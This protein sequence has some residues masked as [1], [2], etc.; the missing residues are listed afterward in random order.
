MC[1]FLILYP[2][3][4][5]VIGS[6]RT[7]M[8]ILMDPFGLPVGFILDNYVHAWENGKLYSLYMN[9]FIVT[10]TSVAVIVLFSSMIAYVMSRKDFK[11]KGLLF[12]VIIVGMTIPAQVGIL[13][14]Y[15]QMV[16]MH[17]AN[18]LI[19]LIIVYVVN[20]LSYSTFIMYGFI[21]KVSKE[22]QEAALI[23]GCGTFR[24]YMHIIMPLS[25][26]VILTITIFNLMFIWNDMFFSMVMMSTPSKKTL[27]VGL[28]GFVGQYQT[29][30]ATMF[31]GVVLVSLPMVILFLILQ[32]KF[33]AG[34]TTGAVKG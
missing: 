8:Q 3:Y 26:P 9:S 20:Y 22:I 6:L 24:N 25:T 32:K 14:L 4:M 1:L 21:R 28:L 27:M 15:L 23:D 17:L 18:T 33:I 31:A 10:L 30:Y 7:N 2:L 29:D 5:V 13:P 12:T 16:K 34:A 19:G 11:L